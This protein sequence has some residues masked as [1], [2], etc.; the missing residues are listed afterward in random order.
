MTVSSLASLKIP[1]VRVISRG[2]T[3]FTQ[4]LW[5]ISISTYLN[6]HGLPVFALYQS[7]PL[8]LNTTKASLN[9]FYYCAYDDKTKHDVC[10]DFI[11]C[12]L[13]GNG[14]KVSALIYRKT[15]IK[16]LS[17]SSPHRGEKRIIERD[18]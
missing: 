8:R 7:Q 12:F 13:S 3:T 9:L 5:F 1:G 15:I 6:Y 10:V 17:S 4:I 16:Y 2:S 14:C 11:T 18:I